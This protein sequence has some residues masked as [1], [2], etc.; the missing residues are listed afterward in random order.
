MLC[1]VCNTAMP[2]RAS[3]GRRPRQFCSP[4]CRAKASLAKAKAEFTGICPVC[5]KSVPFPR[6]YCSLPCKNIAMSTGQTLA[7]MTC[8]FCGKIVI[9]RA[10]LAKRYRYCSLSC[11]R[12]DFARD[13]VL[14]DIDLAFGHWLA[15]L[16][17]GEATFALHKTAPAFRLTL[18]ADD[19]PVL[20]MIRETLGF[21][22]FVRQSRNRRPNENPTIVF[23]TTS[24]K[25]A[26]AVVKLFRQFPLRSKKARDFEIWAE[27]VDAMMLGARGETLAPLASRLVATRQ[28]IPVVPD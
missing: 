11:S 12:R 16:A 5:S 13:I 15:G 20:T 17:D 25:E 6:R 24:A 9:R 22:I 23:L 7:E 3:T 8:L 4:I 10:D 18:R 28:Y 1:P 21:G 27:A 2:D 26:A 14:P 19:E